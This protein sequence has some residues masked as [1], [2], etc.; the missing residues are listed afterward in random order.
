[1]RAAVAELL[2]GLA[3]LSIAVA[4]WN[5]FVGSP[6]QAIALMMLAMVLGRFS[7]VVQ[8]NRLLKPSKKTDVRHVLM[9]ILFILGMTK[10]CIFLS[11]LL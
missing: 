2:M 7:Y 9:I 8:I 3:L 11:H 5:V 6:L 10:A 1:M 4:V